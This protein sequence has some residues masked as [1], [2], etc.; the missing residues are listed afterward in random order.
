[1][2][3]RVKNFAIPGLHWCVGLIVLWESCRFAFGASAMRAFAETGL[4][5]WIRPAL[6]SVEL[7]AAVL[8]LLPATA[9]VGGYALLV[10][11]FLAAIIHILHG[12]YDVSGLVL[13]GMAVLASLANQEGRKGKAPLQVQHD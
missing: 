7:V 11:F 3:E 13:Y 10:I 2:N 5:N 8:F 6:G 12:W 1:M 4:P 9:V